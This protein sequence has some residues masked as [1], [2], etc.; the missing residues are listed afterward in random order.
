M[1]QTADARHGCLH[2]IYDNEKSIRLDAQRSVHLSSHPYERRLPVMLRIPST[3]LLL[4]AL[5]ANAG[6]TPRAVNVGIYAN[7]P[8]IYFDGQGQADGILID[9][10]RTI[11]KTEGWT[12]ASS[13]A[14]GRAALPPWPAAR[15]IFFRTSHGRRNVSRYSTF[16]TFPPCSAGLKSI[17]VQTYRLIQ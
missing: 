15:S 6:A 2:L 16:T 1:A 17:G 8:K 11:A 7:A 14:N 3:L 10:L 13:P 5:H 4:F 12:F 9:L